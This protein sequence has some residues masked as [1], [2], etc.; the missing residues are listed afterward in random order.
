MSAHSPNAE[1]NAPRPFDWAAVNRDRLFAHEMLRA[2][3]QAVEAAKLIWDAVVT[4]SQLNELEAIASGRPYT[5][6]DLK[7]LGRKLE[8]LER[9]AQELVEVERR[10]SDL[11]DRQSSF[12]RDDGVL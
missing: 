6:P 9:Q 3:V 12:S 5:P 4:R 1:P 8:G 11:V 2:A 7:T 10:L